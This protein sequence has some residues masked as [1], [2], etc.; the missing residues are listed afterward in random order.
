M[1]CRLGAAGVCGQRSDE[2]KK[3]EGK[4]RTKPMTN[5]KR[6]KKKMKKRKK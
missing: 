6:L 3:T 2:E 1:A 4:Q 5:R